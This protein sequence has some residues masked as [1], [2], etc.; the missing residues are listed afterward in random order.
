M[1]ECGSCIV[2]GS[3]HEYKSPDIIQ[4][5]K[6]WQTSFFYVKSPDKGPDMLNLPEFK[7]DRTLKKYQWS[8]KI[9]VRDC[10]VDSQVA[11]VAKIF[12]DGLEPYDLVAAWLYARVLPLQSRVHRICDMSGGRD[13]TQICTKKLS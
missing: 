6:D 4:S 11:R 2:S 7:R 12:A 9:G 1:T 13:P 5:C 8:C 10:D 3:K